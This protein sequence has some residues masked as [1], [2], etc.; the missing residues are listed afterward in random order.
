[1]NEKGIREIMNNKEIDLE[2]RVTKLEDSFVSFNN[3]FIALSKTIETQSKDIS[4]KLN[5]LIYRKPETKPLNWNM[6]IIAG[7]ILIFLGVYLLNK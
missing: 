7:S 4:D 2:H 6:V 3:G 1:M 5:L